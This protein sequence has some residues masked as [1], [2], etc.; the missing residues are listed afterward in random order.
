MPRDWVPALRAS[1]LSP[2]AMT[3][4]AID[5]ER[6]VVAN[7]DGTF[8]ALRDVCGHRQASLS[9]GTLHGHVIECPLHFARFD[10]R[11]GRYVDGP[12]SADVPTYEVRVEGDTVYV[13][14]PENR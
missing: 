12:D 10:V 11:D 2:G 8:Y 14:Q 5:R 3:W 6:V 4:V 7:V 13:R 9:Q 1:A